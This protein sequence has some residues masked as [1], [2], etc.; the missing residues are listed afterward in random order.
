[1]NIMNCGGVCNQ[2]ARKARDPLALAARRRRVLLVSAHRLSR[3]PATSTD[4]RAYDM[5]MEQL[6]CSITLVPAMVALFDPAG[7]AALSAYAASRHLTLSCNDIAS[8]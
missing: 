4:H 8:P 7:E 1:M 3:S 6:F 2:A 5:L